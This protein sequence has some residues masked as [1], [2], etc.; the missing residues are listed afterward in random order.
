MT[1]ALLFLEELV[2]KRMKTFLD[3]VQ[4]FVPSLASAA[5]N[6]W[7]EKQGLCNQL[8]IVSHGMYKYFTTF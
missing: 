2:E 3:F 6:F 7:K 8:H 4:L 1:H 5:T